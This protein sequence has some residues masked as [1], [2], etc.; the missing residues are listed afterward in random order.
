MENNKSELTEDFN[1]FK[2]LVD[3]EYEPMNWTGKFQYPGMVRIRV[4]TDGSCFF[5]SI[6]KSYFKPYIMGSLNGNPLNRN[7]F[8]VKLRKDLANKLASKVNPLDPQSPIYYDTLSRGNLREISQSLPNYSLENMI[9]ELNSNHP[10]DN[11]YNEF[12]SNQLNKDIYLL[13]LVNQ[14]IYITGSDDDILYKN[15]PSIVI[16]YIPG[17]YELVGIQNR[18]SIETVF[19]STHPFIQAIQKRKK[20]I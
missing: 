4:P 20:S 18:D 10:V 1:R 6:A 2:Y 9:H 12:I 17:H 3:N 19:E 8:I 5:H 13:D 15:R 14:D 7:D 16:L 11:V